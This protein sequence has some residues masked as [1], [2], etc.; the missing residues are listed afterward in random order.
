MTE[1]SRNDVLES[2]VEFVRA[3]LQLEDK[4]GPEYNPSRQSILFSGKRI[5]ARR[6]YIFSLEVIAAMD[7]QAS[8]KLF[9]DRLMGRRNAMV[10]TAIVMPRSLD[11]HNANPTFHCPYLRRAN[12]LEGLDDRLFEKFRA[13][14][15]RDSVFLLSDFETCVAIP[16]SGNDVA[17][18]NPKT[19]SIEVFWFRQFPKRKII[20]FN[21]ETLGCRLNPCWDLW[22]LRNLDFLPENR[23]IR[24]STE[25]F[26]NKQ[27]HLH[28]VV[29]QGMKKQD[30]AIRES[31]SLEPYRSSQLGVY[32]ARLIS[33]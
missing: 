18:Y 31:F 24:R 26:L 30:K 1:L 15:Y 23:G 3:N 28:R 5:G 32:G 9:L 8:V 17:Y 12:L 11:Y 25:I 4:R 2:M 19:D 16:L 20:P 29:R 13:G 21:E 7:R 33:C 14:F 10:Y 27:R 6:E 22:Y